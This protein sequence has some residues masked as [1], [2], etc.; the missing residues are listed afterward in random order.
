MAASLPML[1]HHTEV[2]AVIDLNGPGQYLPWGW[3]QV[4]W[5]NLVVVLLMLAVFALALLLPFPH[6]RGTADRERGEQP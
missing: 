4:S 6:R 2:V 1:V 3:L 5:A